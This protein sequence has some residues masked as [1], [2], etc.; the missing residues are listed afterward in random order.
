[1]II[2]LQGD[3]GG[4]AIGSS[5]TVVGVTSNGVGCGRDGQPGVYTRA[6]EF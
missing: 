4:P 1:M 3:S 5:D 6:T 2:Y